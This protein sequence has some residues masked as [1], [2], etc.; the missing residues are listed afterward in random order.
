[1]AALEAKSQITI[2]LVA[3]IFVFF[4]YL[5]ILMSTTW[6]YSLAVSILSENST[7]S[8]A[9]LWL[10]F[11]V[12]TGFIS[13]IALVFSTEH[14]HIS[15][16][17]GVFFVCLLTILIFA[18]LAWQGKIKFIPRSSNSSPTTLDKSMFW[19]CSGLLTVATVLSVI[20]P[21]LLIIRTF[22]GGYESGSLVFIALFI[23]MT[24]L[25]SLIPA[26]VFFATTGRA[27]R[28]FLYGVTIA[29]I[30]IPPHLI[31]T[32]GALSNIS[33]AAA[34]KLEIRQ[35]FV[36]RFVLDERFEITQ[37]DNLQWHTR[38]TLKGRIEVDG[39]QLFSFGEALLI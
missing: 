39:F 2:W 10:L 1:M 21:A 31:V 38:L 8:K 9:A 16:L 28:R 30:L 18:I 20:S 12:T 27:H 34:R 23:L 33:Y 32:Q 7:D 37:L 11:P 26:I 6:C 36:S 29:L 13:L 25:C 17:E 5:F 4:A 3:T 24:A 14:T 22:D 35:D 15:P 19:L